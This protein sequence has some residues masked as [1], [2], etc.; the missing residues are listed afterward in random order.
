MFSLLCFSIGLYQHVK[1]RL[2]FV[3][4]AKIYPLF[5][6]TFIGNEGKIPKWNEWN[7]K[8][9]FSG[10]SGIISFAIPSPVR[11][12]ERKIPGQKLRTDLPF[13]C[14]FVSF[15]RHGFSIRSPSLGSSIRPTS[16]LPCAGY[17]ISG[18]TPV[19]PPRENRWRT[20]VAFV[21]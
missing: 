15:A 14:S 9:I 20:I 8:V 4:I 19:F 18:R 21:G 2:F 12:T 11:S 5:R 1:E 16:A 7:G 17:R 6:F 10:T 13:T 3:S